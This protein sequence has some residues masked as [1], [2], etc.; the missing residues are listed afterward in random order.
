MEK[1]KVFAVDGDIIAYRSAA[2]CENEFEGAAE[3][4][5]RT[6]IRDICVDT[7]IT[8]IR[9]YLSA[10]NNFRYN[11]A[12]TKP[13]KGNRA[14]MV[15][16]QFLNHCKDY[17]IKEYGAV[18]VDTFEADDCI[19]TDMMVNNAIHCGIDKDLLQ[20]PGM[21]YNYVKKQ[22]ITVTPEEAILCLYRQVL[23]GDTSDNVP[24]LPLIGE[25]KAFDA[26]QNHETA[27]EDAMSFYE[28]VCARALPNVNYIEYMAEQL[29]LIKM[30][31]DVPLSF[32]NTHIVDIADGFVAQGEE[33]TVE[34]KPKT[35]IKL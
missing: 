18:L 31:C 21:H 27:A 10:S 6:T 29:Q 3:S 28:T 17:L 19:A 5:I 12:K 30:V 9:V 22:W 13:Y 35:K 20:I 24:G 11:V 26:I 32:D 23:M 25:K 14:T 15:K 33:Q 1:S 34:D 4:I 16:P 8:D 7:G 2:V